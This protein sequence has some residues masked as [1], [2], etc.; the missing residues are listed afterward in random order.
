MGT[1]AAIDMAARIGGATADVATRVTGA[2]RDAARA[3]GAGFD[4]LLNSEAQGRGGVSTRRERPLLGLSGRE[5]ARAH[6]G[7][8]L[9]RA[10][11]RSKR[12]WTRHPR[13]GVK[14]RRYCPTRH[15]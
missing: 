13:R 1:D 2:I 14:P 7:T 8:G 11:F 4:Y 9:G 10:R 5:R 12:D 3:T 15:A 6:A